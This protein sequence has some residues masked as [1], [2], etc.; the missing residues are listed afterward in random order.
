MAP[1]R[2]GV[3]YTLKAK[4]NSLSIHFHNVDFD[5]VSDDPYRTVESETH[6]I[7]LLPER[8]TAVVEVANDEGLAAGEE[9][10]VGPGG[11]VLCVDFLPRV[12]GSVL[13]MYAISWDQVA[14]FMQPF[15][16]L[17]EPSERPVVKFRE[18]EFELGPLESRWMRPVPVDHDGD[19]GVVVEGRSGV[20]MFQEALESIFGAGKR[21]LWAASESQPPA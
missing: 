19:E 17:V 4:A 6:T 18:G 10:L 5:A 2:T 8:F 21:V 7:T 15:S 13:V 3:F 14:I 11:A 1:Q 12:F 20:E 16:A 9:V